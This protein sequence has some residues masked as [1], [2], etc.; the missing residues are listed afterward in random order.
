MRLVIST[1]AVQRILA[2]T[3]IDRLLDI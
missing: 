1:P 3:G 2:I